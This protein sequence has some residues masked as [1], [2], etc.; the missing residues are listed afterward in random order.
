MPVPEIV[1]NP[2]PLFI[3]QACAT[4]GEA[5]KP[6]LMLRTLFAGL[7]FFFTSADTG[8]PADPLPQ[9]GS[10][11][12]LLWKADM[13]LACF[14]TNVVLTDN[15]IVMG[16]NGQGVTDYTVF[17][18]K[19]GVYMINRK[20]GKLIRQFAD[21]VLGDMDVAG[22]LLYN[23]RCFFGNDNEEF[24]CTD[25]NG[26][27]VWRNPAS[28]D[29][30]HQPVLIRRGNE[31]I[32]VYATETG[33]VRAVEPAT[34][35]KVW[36]YFVPDFDGY[37]DGDNRF[38]FK[39]KSYMNYK[40]DLLQKP[41]LADL[42]RDG[43]PDLVYLRQR[44]SLIAL[45][46]KTGGLLWQYS[47]EHGFRTPHL[48]KTG[49]PE[50]P[51]FWV[52]GSRYE[53]RETYA[54]DTLYVVNGRG[55]LLAKKHFPHSESGESINYMP[56]GGDT[57]LL[58]KN[59][60]LFLIKGD[61]IVR[62]IPYRI[63]YDNP[64]EYR[65]YAYCRDPLF[66]EKVFSYDGHPRCILMLSQRGIRDLYKATLEIISLDNGEV[67]KRLILPAGSEMPPQ[68]ED[69]NKDG[70]PDLLLNCWDGFLY[71]YSLKGKVGLN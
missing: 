29:I 58:N 27:V 64:D 32:I 49:T 14:R 70:Q 21:D 48:I 57:I 41:E 33:E 59:D 43:T 12:P 16:S 34:G 60:S 46:G 50:K 6:L 67:L 7:F 15:N 52:Y 39:L 8:D 19:S 45:N 18:S 61:Q 53:L 4:T 36:S 25:L 20:S 30:E 22:I 66:A 28:G 55:K 17:D 11:F 40:C 23:N 62:T 10:E 54:R 65:S 35:K 42:N 56:I 26:K 71:C 37:R 1:R 44:S 51:C 13:G 69:V 9:I 63:Y 3:H 47:G 24:L 31:D 5:A 2:Y 38:A 68:I